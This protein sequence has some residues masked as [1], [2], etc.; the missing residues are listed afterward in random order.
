MENVQLRAFQEADL[1]HFFR[2]EQD[3]DAQ[4]MAAFIPEN[5]QDRSAFDAHWRK[6]LAMD[7]VVARTILL[8]GEVCGH[9]IKFE[10]EGEPEITYW[11]DRR[12][13]GKGIATKALE[14]LLKEVLQRPIYSRTAADNVASQ[15]VLEK[16]GFVKSGEDQGFANARKEIIREF[17]YRRD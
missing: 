4:W 14:L 11:I 10:I 13:W 5:F 15:H 6:I 17:I 3:Q 1:D 9:I 8:E 7:S 2:H 12:H 16:N